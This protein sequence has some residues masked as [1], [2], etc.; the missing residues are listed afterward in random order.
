MARGNDG[1][2]V[3]VA[4]VHYAR[5]D[6]MLPVDDARRPLTPAPVYNYRGNVTSRVETDVDGHLMHPEAPN[7][8]ALL[9]L[10]GRKPGSGHGTPAMESNQNDTVVINGGHGHVLPDQHRRHSP[11]V[12]G[13]GDHSGHGRDGRNDRDRINNV[14]DIHNMSDGNGINGHVAPARNQCGNTTVPIQ[15]V[16]IANHGTGVN[17]VKVADSQLAHIRDVRQDA[18]LHSNGILR[19]PAQIYNPCQI[20]TFR[21]TRIRTPQPPDSNPSGE[22][23]NGFSGT[24]NL[25]E[26]NLNA[27]A[28][29]SQKATDVRDL[30][31]STELGLF[32]LGLLICPFPPPDSTEPHQHQPVSDSLIGSFNHFAVSSTNTSSR[33]TPRSTPPRRLRSANAEFLHQLSPASR[34][35]L[36]VG[37]VEVLHSTIPQMDRLLSNLHRHNIGYLHGISMQQQVGDDVDEMLTRLVH[38]KGLVGYLIQKAKRGSGDDECE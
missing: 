25:V 32:Q 11:T 4:P 14:H 18:R 2:P 27:I 23:P 36:Q 10:G 9:A 22:R 35:Y 8:E 30:C 3:T 33:A 6:S 34:H 29:L 5:E 20:S 12:V 24:V 37:A 15:S 31:K 17:G 28:T 38:T 21:R 7:Q 19:A 13:K 16:K 26:E 1:I